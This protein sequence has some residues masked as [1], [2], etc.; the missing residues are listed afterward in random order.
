MRTVYCALAMLLYSVPLLAQTKDAAQAKT[1]FKPGEIVEIKVVFEKKLP[2]DASVKIRY[3]IQADQTDQNDQTDACNF[4]RV[5]EL[6]GGR[7]SD[8]LTFVLT[9]NIPTEI[10][11]G[12]YVLTQLEV[13]AG[14]RL[15]GAATGTQASNAPTIPVKNTTPCRKPEPIVVPDFKITIIKP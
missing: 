8:N 5:I 11:S 14:D 1:E 13:S 7:S 12:T 15:T 6:S 10:R 2:T 9:A 4:R 3:A